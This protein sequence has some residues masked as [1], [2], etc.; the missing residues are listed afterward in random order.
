MAQAPVSRKPRTKEYRAYTSRNYR[1][2]PQVELLNEKLRHGIDVVSQVLPFKTNNYVVE[3]LI[4]WDDV[5][6]DP[7]FALTF[8][9]ADM[10]RPEHFARVDVERDAHVSICGEFQQGFARLEKALF[11]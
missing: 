7:M 4:H 6:N 10:L 9:Q 3:E 8:P 1:G 5:P 2:I 11:R